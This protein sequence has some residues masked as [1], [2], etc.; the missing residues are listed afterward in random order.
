MKK[1][2]S[3]LS[4]AVSNT[5]NSMNMNIIQALSRERDIGTLKQTLYD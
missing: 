5:I 4:I 1:I 3:D 2:F